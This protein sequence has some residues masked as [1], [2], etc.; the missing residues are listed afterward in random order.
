MEMSIW[1]IDFAI[2]SPFKI[3][4]LM[5]GNLTSLSVNKMS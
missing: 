2:L 4:P 5:D 3:R 1:N